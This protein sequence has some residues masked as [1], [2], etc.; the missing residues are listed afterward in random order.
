M[1]KVLFW[2]FISVILILGLYT[3]PGQPSWIIPYWLRLV[4]LWGAGG[5]VVDAFNDWIKKKGVSL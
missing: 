3:S 5:L 4:I 1:K 2:M